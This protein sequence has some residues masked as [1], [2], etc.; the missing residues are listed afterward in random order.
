MILSSDL[1]DKDPNTMFDTLRKNRPNTFLI[2]YTLEKSEITFL[3]EL[4]GRSPITVVQQ[5]KSCDGVYS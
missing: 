2:P 4:G 3:S 1:L 5:L